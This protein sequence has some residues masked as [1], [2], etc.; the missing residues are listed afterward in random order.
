MKQQEPQREPQSSFGKA[1]IV[2]TTFWEA[3]FLLN[4]DFFLFREKDTVYRSLLLT[5]PRYIPNYTVNSVAL[6]HPTLKD[7]KNIH[8]INKLDFLCPTFKMLSEYEKKNDWNKYRKEYSDLLKS[9]KDELKNWA[10]SLE[11]DRIYFLC[12]WENTSEGSHCH[13]EIIHEALASSKNANEKLIAIYKHGDSIYSLKDRY[14][15]ALD[16]SVDSPRRS[17]RGEWNE[18]GQSNGAWQSYRED[19]VSPRPNVGSFSVA[20]VDENLNMHIDPS[21]YTIGVD[22]AVGESSDIIL[23][24][25]RTHVGSDDW[26]DAIVGTL[27]VPEELL[28]VP[29]R[30]RRVEGNTDDEWLD[31]LLSSLDDT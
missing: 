5:D 28:S 3:D 6:S 12:C 16:K 20:D 26:L 17:R 7:L 25:S 27:G 15:D 22:P 29:E 11:P 30:E 9:R 8:E 14:C 19:V 10:N 24:P 18:L 21:G 1:I 2:L 13:R 4:N 31:E 23:S